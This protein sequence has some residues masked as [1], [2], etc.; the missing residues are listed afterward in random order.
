MAVITATEDRKQVPEK[1]ASVRRTPAP[2]A[3]HSTTYRDRWERGYARLL[4][5][6]DSLVVIACLVAVTVAG[7]QPYTLPVLHG[8]GDV[9]V[10]LVIGVLIATLLTLLSLTG[11]RN[12]RVVGVGSQEYR[13]I[14]QSSFLAFTSLA[15]L[16]YVTSLA[17]LHFILAMG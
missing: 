14:V 13:A 12:A 17:G 15:L 16:A 4:V 3:Q 8:Q 5:V 11:S 9:S 1:S 6:T 2:P 7:S 10:W